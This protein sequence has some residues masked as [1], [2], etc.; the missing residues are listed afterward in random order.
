M[1]EST[2]EDF[3]GISTEQEMAPQKGITLRTRTPSGEICPSKLKSKRT[4][5]SEATYCSSKKTTGG[6]TKAFICFLPF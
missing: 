6:G 4:Q 2:F 5:G 1:L 3:K